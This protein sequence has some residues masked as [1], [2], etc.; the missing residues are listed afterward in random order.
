MGN[1]KSGVRKVKIQSQRRKSSLGRVI[2]LQNS[3]SQDIKQS[4]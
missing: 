1:S 4:K 3:Q 2:Q